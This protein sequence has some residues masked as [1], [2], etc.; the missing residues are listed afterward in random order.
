MLALTPPRHTCC[1]ACEEQLGEEM[2]ASSHERR[3]VFLRAGEGIARGLP[4]SFALAPLWLG[5]LARIWLSKI[6]E[7]QL[8]S[9][10]FL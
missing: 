7:S 3:E 8:P 5:S 1:E 2:G 9:Q 10:D 4:H 6:I